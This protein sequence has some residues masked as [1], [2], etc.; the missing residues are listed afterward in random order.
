MSNRRLAAD[1]GVS[2]TTI[3]RIRQ[4]L[5]EYLNAH[6]KDTDITNMKRFPYNICGNKLYPNLVPKIHELRT[7]SVVITKKIIKKMAIKE[8]YA[9]V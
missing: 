2:K 3:N 9:I 6:E 7:K 8:A 4:R 5:D 1:F